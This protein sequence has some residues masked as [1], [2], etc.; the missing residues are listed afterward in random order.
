MDDPNL[1]LRQSGT[2]DIEYIKSVPG[3]LKITEIVGIILPVSCFKSYLQFKYIYSICH[4]ISKSEPTLINP[5]ITVT[6]CSI[7]YLTVYS[8]STLFCQPKTK[9]KHTYM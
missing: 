2:L 6:K 7:S 4:V 5:S 3:L 8:S 9:L 1:R